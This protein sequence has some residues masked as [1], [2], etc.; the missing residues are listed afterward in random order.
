MINST[1]IRIHTLEEAL[2][3]LSKGEK[4]RH[5]ATTSLN[6]NSS[7]SHTIFRV[8]ITYCTGEKK[9]MS[10]C[11]L[12][13]LAGSEKISLFSNLDEKQ[14]VVESK[15]INKS[16]F[17][18]THII[19]LLGQR[20]NANFIPYRNSTLTKILKN[21]IGGNALTAIILCINPLFSSLEQTL[22]T[23]KFG[24]VAQNIENIVSK[25]EIVEGLRAQDTN[26]RDM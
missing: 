26:E 19:N 20:I 11:N 25:N 23:L 15:N 16:L 8:T 9:Y 4:N 7:R 3:V 6:H 2:E 5:F 24:S 13:D 18:L 14:R 22:S 21:S 1:S 17:F 10:V 12:V